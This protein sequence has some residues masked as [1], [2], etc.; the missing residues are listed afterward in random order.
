[1]TTATSVTSDTAAVGAAEEPAQLS[2]SWP[3]GLMLL[4]LLC[5]LQLCTEHDAPG[6]VKFKMFD[7][8]RK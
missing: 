7:A 2:T 5:L 1:M 4:C 8:K 3:A 6:F